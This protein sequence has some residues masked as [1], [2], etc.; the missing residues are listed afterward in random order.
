MYQG[1]V[2]SRKRAGI[3][4]TIHFHLS[5]PLEIT[6]KFPVSRSELGLSQFI[7]VVYAPC[8][9][10]LRHWKYQRLRNFKREYGIV[11]GP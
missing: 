5:M 11:L 4:R 3:E 2:M 10:K 9:M 8:M 7:Q 6:W 1:R